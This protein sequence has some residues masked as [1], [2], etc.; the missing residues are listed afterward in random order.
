MTLSP[1]VSA[2]RPLKIAT[3]ARDILS[4]RNV[5]CRS[6]SPV[7]A[8]W[9]GREWSFRLLPVSATSADAACYVECDWGGARVFLA[10]SAFAAQ[11]LSAGLLGLDAGMRLPS[12]LVLACVEGALGDLS[13]SIENGTRKHVQLR[14]VTSHAPQ[15]GSH[16]RYAWQAWTED[17][18]LEGELLLDASA[19]RYLAAAFR[20]H[21]LE[22]VD[23][24]WQSLAVRAS[25]LVGWVDLSHEAMAQLACRD[26]IVLD[27]SLITR[28]NHVVLQLGPGVGLRCRLEG[29]ELKVIQGVHEIM[30]DLDSGDDAD[31]AAGILDGIPV[32]LTFDLG[33][34]EIALAELKTLRPGYIFNLGRDPRA[35]VNI[36]VNGKLMGEGELVDIEGR[37][38][39][40]ILRLGAEVQAP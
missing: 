2:A 15:G 25:L 1:A 34:R 36:R 23:D 39:V 20:E 19:T 21:P 29:Q 28:D 30:S 31:A 13:A 26:V 22:P 6:R 10:L 35:G 14:D 18:R 40:C 5:L 24:A 12:E 8:V 11:E 4:A 37:I 17:A 7:R 9:N 16:E 3:V 32:R 27:E 33:D 38:G